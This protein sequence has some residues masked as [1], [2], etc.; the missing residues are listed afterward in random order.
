MAPSSRFRQSSK[1]SGADLERERLPIYL[2]GYAAVPPRPE[3]DTKQADAGPS[4]WALVF[5]TE[6]TADDRPTQYLRFGAF[7]LLEGR[8]L[9]LKGIFFDPEVLDE[10]QV[11]VLRAESARLGYKLMHL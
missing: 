8:Q 1:L 4:E 11:E 6:P 10:E 5:D 2:R 3:R 7:Q 9:A